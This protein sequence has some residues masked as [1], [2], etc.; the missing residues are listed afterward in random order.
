MFAKGILFYKIKS[1]S[2]LFLKFLFLHRKLF[3]KITNKTIK[4]FKNFT[5]SFDFS[6]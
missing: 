3:K 5:N 2:Y 1:V 4:L 6:R